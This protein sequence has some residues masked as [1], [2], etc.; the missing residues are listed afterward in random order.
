MQ[1][2]YEKYLGEK[3]VKKDAKSMDPFMDEYTSLVEKINEL[4]LVSNSLRGRS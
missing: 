2:R 4:N 1:H 3:E